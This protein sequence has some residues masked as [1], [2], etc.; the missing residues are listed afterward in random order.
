MLFR[1]S[2]RSNSH[3]DRLYPGEGHRLPL[4]QKNL[5][6]GEIRDERLYDEPIMLSKVGRGQFFDGLP[7]LFEL[8]KNLIFF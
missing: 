4:S 2:F 5:E 6:G 7:P 1:N 8:H 3:G